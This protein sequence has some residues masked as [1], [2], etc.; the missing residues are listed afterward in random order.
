MSIRSHT[1]KP[2]GSS[3]KPSGAIDFKDDF[4]NPSASTHDETVTHILQRLEQLQTK[5]SNQP[6]QPAAR[7]DLHAR[8]STLESIHEDAL[9]RLTTKLDTVERQLS[10]NKEAEAIL[11]RISSKFHVLESQLNS[12]KEA[13][14]ILGRIS[15]KFNTLENQLSANKETEALV[16]KI[17]SKFEKLEAR[18]QSALAVQDRLDRLEA[19]AERHSSQH[20]R[21][22]KLETRLEPDPEEQRLIQRVTAKLDR[23]ENS[24]TTKS[25]NLG[26]SF[27]DTEALSVNDRDDKIAELKTRIR[28]LKELRS[29]YATEE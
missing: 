2:N 26:T 1:D 27:D 13:E 8:L 5:I 19:S 28:K 4:V 29:K 17:A 16:S 20:A 3:T 18:L 22:T 6:E 10:D 14:E 21:I 11:G 12:N 25:I 9:H 7:G 24:R 15:T 23:L